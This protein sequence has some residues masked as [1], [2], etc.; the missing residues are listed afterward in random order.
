ME[1][2]LAITLCVLANISA[3]L[4]FKR[5]MAEIGT[6]LTIG[7]VKM[8]ITRPWLWLGF[9]CASVVLASYLYA[10]RELPVGLAYSIV[11][12]SVVVGTLVCGFLLFNESLAIRSLAG[13]FFIGVGMVL[14]A[15]QQIG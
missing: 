8:V 13:I 4:C 12:S 11:T 5:A 6:P 1:K 3:N 10:I 2:W 15:S 9:L 14:I 7:A